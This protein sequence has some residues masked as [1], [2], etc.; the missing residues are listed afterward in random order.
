MRRY[1]TLGFPVAFQLN[2]DEIL[3]VDAF[4]EEILHTLVIRPLKS[5]LASLFQEDFQHSGC[6]QL[7]R[8][9]MEAAAEVKVKG[10]AGARGL[11]PV[12][13]EFAA[14]L[15]ETREKCEVILSDLQGS[16][17]PNDKLDCLLQIIKVILESVS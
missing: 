12:P 14:N 15:A 1:L 3:T 8:D 17:S 7:L 4:L 9:N 5:H 11:D 16:I 13:K 10:H 6:L 2:S